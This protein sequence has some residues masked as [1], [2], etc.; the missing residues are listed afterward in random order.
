[1][2][3][4]ISKEERK[5]FEDAVA[6]LED[7]KDKQ[8][9]PTIHQRLVCQNVMNW[10]REFRGIFSNSG[11]YFLLFLENTVN[12]RSGAPANEISAYEGMYY[13]LEN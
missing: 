3:L 5:G 10:T 11:D 2:K 8:C 12:Q 7:F 1:M 9:Q 4:P 6:Y 13:L